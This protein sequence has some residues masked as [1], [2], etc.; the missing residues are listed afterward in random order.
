MSAKP[1]LVIRIPME[2]SSHKAE[3]SKQL[4]ELQEKMSD[5]HVISALDSGVTVTKFECYNPPTD[6]L[7]IEK[8]SEIEQKIN[9]YIFI[10]KESEK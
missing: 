10:I 6:E 3:L 1:I 4:K 5:Y 7:T 8:L 2:A 9:E